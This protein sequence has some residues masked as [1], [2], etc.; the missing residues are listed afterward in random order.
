MKTII[1][2]GVLLASVGNVHAAE[3]GFRSEKTPCSFVVQR[4]EKVVNFMAMKGDLSTKEQQD[5]TLL[6]GFVD[7]V[8]AGFLMNDKMSKEQHGWMEGYETPLD[9]LEGVVKV[10]RQAPTLSLGGAIMYMWFWPDK[11]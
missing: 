4:V 11:K 10:C 6:S 8:R 1:F 2:A 7:G 9:L 3:S 5:I